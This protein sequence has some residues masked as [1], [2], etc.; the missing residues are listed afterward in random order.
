VSAARTKRNAIGVTAAIAFLVVLLTACGGDGSAGLPTPTG[1][2]TPGLPSR[3]A[4][5]APPTRTASR[6]VET[7][8]ETV[9]QAPSPSPAPADEANTSNASDGSDVP[10]WVWWLLAG[11]CLLGAVLALILVPRARRRSSWDAR[12]A[13]AEQEVSWLARD[14]LPQLQ[15]AGSPAE[16]AGGWQVAAGRVT[17]IEDTLTGLESAAPDSSRAR[18]ARVMRDAVRGAR[19]GM[20]ALLVSRDAT[21]LARDLAAIATQ[22][23]AALGAP[24]HTS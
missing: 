21:T 15:R 10:S 4:T 24:A 8:S 9:S 16:V 6:S 22:L 5:L 23:S 3:T 7:P 13:S 14:L 12:L 19:Q 11:L 2:N 17:L 20:E 1:S 18:R